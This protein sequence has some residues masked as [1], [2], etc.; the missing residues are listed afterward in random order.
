MTLA[1]FHF[2][3]SDCYRTLFKC[4]CYKRLTPALYMEVGCPGTWGLELL[5]PNP[6]SESTPKSLL[7][8]QPNHES[9]PPYPAPAQAPVTQSQELCRNNNNSNNDNNNGNNN[10]NKR[11]RSVGENTTKSD[12]DAPATKH[13]KT[14]STCNDTRI[15]YNNNRWPGH[16][17][18][19][20]APGLL[21]YRKP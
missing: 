5:T 8:P 9:R 13:S 4:S 12:Q 21:Q 19:C 10:N 15:N 17:G 18:N 7:Y 14:L 2:K 1:S 16:T 11:K 20:S 3:T 6:D